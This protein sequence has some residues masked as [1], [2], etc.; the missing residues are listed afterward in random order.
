MSLIEFNSPKP[1]DCHHTV[2]PPMQPDT[3]EQWGDG[4]ASRDSIFQVLATDEAVCDQQ[5]EG[6]QSATDLPQLHF[7]RDALGGNHGVRAQRIAEQGLALTALLLAKDADYGNS[8][9]QPP[10]LAPELP[11]EMAIRVR[12]S[13][14]LNRIN[15]LLGS[16]PQHRA[17]TLDDT[18][19]D[20]A[21]YFLLWLI[22]RRAVD[23]PRPAA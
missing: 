5:A 13:D 20:A 6:N 9:A 22:E 19:R 17:E 16:E 3:H 8:V 7:V 10:L 14:K 11:P 12:I 23:D 2:I 15:Q 1:E 4:P 21:G 18:L